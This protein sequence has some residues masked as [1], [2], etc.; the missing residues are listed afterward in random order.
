MIFFSQHSL[1]QC[2]VRMWFNNGH[3]WDFRILSGSDLNQGRFVSADSE[4]QGPV[5][6]LREGVG[7]KYG[8][9]VSTDPFPGWY[10]SPLNLIFLFFCCCCCLILHLLT[11]WPSR[12]KQ[13]SGHHDVSDVSSS[14]LPLADEGSCSVE[15]QTVFDPASMLLSP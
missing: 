8:F 5:R 6:I 10:F 9:H 7:L 4:C 2:I 12:M 14:E 3:L 1:P 13:V 15:T 11:P